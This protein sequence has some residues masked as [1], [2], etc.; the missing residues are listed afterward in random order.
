MPVGKGNGGAE[1]E[2]R[3]LNGPKAQVWL[4][5]R[6]FSDMNQAAEWTSVQMVVPSGFTYPR[7]VLDMQHIHYRAG[8][9]FLR[10]GE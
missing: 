1:D 8:P 4:E 5:G 9:Y 7:N 3:F 10:F 2:Q 6:G